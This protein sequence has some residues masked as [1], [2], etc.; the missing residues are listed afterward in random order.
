MV[1]LTPDQ[2]AELVL[3]QNRAWKFECPSPEATTYP[4]GAPLQA[5]GLPSVKFSKSP[6]SIS[7]VPLWS[8]RKTLNTGLATAARQKHNDPT[9]IARKAFMLPAGRASSPRRSETALSRK[10]PYLVPN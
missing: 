4:L 6:F 3:S 5:M 2:D 1:W 8:S 7:W 10:A 9:P